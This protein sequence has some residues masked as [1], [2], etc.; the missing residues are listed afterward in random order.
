RSL[1]QDELCL[2]L[3]IV[4]RPFHEIWQHKLLFP[5][6]AQAPL[7][8]QLISKTF[9][10]VLGNTD[11]ALRLLPFLAAVGALCLAP[12]FFRRYLDEKA[13]LLALLFF[14][15][16]EPLVY[17]AAELKPYGV[18]LLM[19][20]LIYEMF[21]AADRFRSWRAYILFALGGAMAL[22]C[23]NTA[24]FVLFALG[25][26]AFLKAVLAKDRRT[27]LF[28]TG[29]YLVWM[30][31][32]GL[33]YWISL[34]RMMNQELMG[35]WSFAFSQGPFWSLAGLSWVKE[36]WV[37]AFSHPLGLG[38]PGM[39]LAF[40]LIGAVG[41]FRQDRERFF[42]LAVPLFVTFLLAAVK[43]YPFHERLILFLVP[44]FLAFLSSGI[45]SLFRVLLK[46]PG[47]G[48]LMG[49]VF[50]LVLLWAPVRVAAHGLISRREFQD[51]R[52]VIK[53]LAQKYQP[54]DEIFFIPQAQYPLWYY[55]QR[56]GLGQELA[57]LGIAGPNGE[58]G[59][60]L[61]Q[62][63]PKTWEEKGVDGAVFRR[64]INLYDMEGM[65]RKFLAPPALSA[66]RFVA[67]DDPRIL[68]GARRMWLIVSHCSP[69]FTAFLRRVFSGAGPEIDSFEAPGA[70]VFLY[71]VS[72]GGK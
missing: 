72:D 28:L 6:F 71:D 16:S 13:A 21:W 69:E 59:V 8:F 26:I 23:A 45:M 38:Y 2:A 65:F 39:M 27:C 54:G 41:I 60:F 31:S 24:L 4:H 5:D 70:G 3:S 67:V 17:F 58:R 40:F 12:R 43:K 61:N 1:W 47:A 25:M 20:F 44:L 18:E 36:T 56:F 35:N 66:P 34:S 62:L 52:A 32:F 7:F 15:L 9:V 64:V 51:N 33:L 11:G 10:Q 19:T 46:V 30:L 14:A 68:K 37:R 48:R 57:R 49:G 53:Y 63:L 22:W 29:S 50:L 42:S 55:G